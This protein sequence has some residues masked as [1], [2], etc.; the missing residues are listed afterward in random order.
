MSE[1]KKTSQLM[2]T[3]VNQMELPY[4]EVMAFQGTQ[5]LFHKTIKPADCAGR[6]KLLLYSCTKPV[7]AVC[8]MQLVERGIISLEDKLVDYVPAFAESCFVDENGDKQVVGGEITLRHLLTMSAGLD[9]NLMRNS[10][11]LELIAKCPDATTE[12]VVDAIA[13]S[14]LNFR[15]GERFLYSLCHDVLGRVIEVVSGK[16]F[17]EYVKGNVFDPLEMYDCGFKMDDPDRMLPVYYGGKGF[18]EP[19]E[20][21]RNLYLL[22]PTTE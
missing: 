21:A 6:D 11:V 3:L 14:P 20:R 22:Y 12:Q 10:A 7:T 17:S 4:L 2:E 9:Y 15:P 1:F 8:T 19:Q 5:Q 18:V 13:K 16:K